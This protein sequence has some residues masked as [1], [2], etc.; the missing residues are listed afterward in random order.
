[1]DKNIAKGK[2]LEEMLQD[3]QELQT[4]L[5]CVPALI[6]YKDKGNRII[7]ANK[8][9]ATT[10]GKPIQDIINRS[11]SE[12]FPDDADRYLSDDQDVIKSGE[13]KY[14]IIEA[15][16]TPYGKKWLQTN[17]IP[18]RDS[19]GNI[20]GIIGF[21]VD[22]TDTILA[23]KSLRESEA[24][25][26]SLITNI[27]NVTWTTDSQG[28]TT[29]ISPNVENIYGYTP[30]E[31]CKKG[32]DLWF[33]RIHPADAGKVKNAFKEL[34]ENGTPL[35]VEYRIQRKDGQW[36]WLHDRSVTTYQK[37]GI[38]Y[39][40]GVL[41]DVTKRKQTQQALKDSEEKLRTI[42]EHGM[43]GILL[44]DTETKKFS[45][46]NR[47]VCQMLGYTED[48]LKNLG[49]EDIHPEQDLPYTIGQFEKLHRKESTIAKD[50]PVKRKDGTIFYV[51]IS[52]AP[53]Q[54]GGKTYVVGIF[55]NITHRKNTEEDLKKHRDRLEQLVNERTAELTE[56]NKQLEL[57]I[58]HHRQADKELIATKE[59]LQHLLTC[60]PV[61]IYACEPHANYAATYITENVL[62]Q[63]GYTQDEFIS[64]PDFWVSHIHPEDKER[65]IAGLSDI[66]QKDSYKYEYRFQYKDGSYHW[67]FDE[68]KVIH[69]A[70]GNATEI[71]GS[72]LD[73]TELKKAEEVMESLN[74]ELGVMVQ[75][76]NQSNYE[77]QDFIHIVAHDL[78]SPL[79]AI[80]ILTTL[81]STDYN[82]RFDEKGHEK[83]KLLLGRTER[84]N[85]LIEGILQYAG[86]KRHIQ[87]DEKVD[88]N[89]LTIEVITK[90]QPP[91]NIKITFENKLP[92]LICE[93]SH[94]TQVFQNLIDNAV[95]YMDKP[96][97]QIKIGCVEQDSLWRF[98][99]AD[100]GPGI[101]EKHCEKIFKPLQTLSA[102]DEYESTGIGLTV[103]KKIVELYN[104]KIW[105]ESK[106]G[107]GSTFFFTL[108]KQE[109]E[110]VSTSK[111][112]RNQQGN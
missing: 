42:F 54:L 76:L 3:N 87:K 97:G 53:V 108:P 91:E 112:A 69:D 72:V 79:R 90:I 111:N 29:F 21:S 15:M 107:K 25:Y 66:L 16:N 98:S 40:D 57:E 73:I 83:I 86:L 32:H 9:L 62:E 96:K 24:K 51:D 10:L 59:S 50:I 8:A 75:K 52:G 27:P 58:S 56:V 109:V 63:F 6:F 47:S 11:C 93:K 94:M 95:K 26:R 4:V 103:T 89:A 70:N 14:N 7:R 60:S 30:E 110:S 102:R 35:D 39:A 49:I 82:D 78:K 31:I 43:D 28:N 12:L 71:V 2:Q 44:A 101:E 37:Y 48:E 13:P 45:M 5:D 18:Y 33:G 77:L 81:L 41:S 61:V 68:L 67:V 105:I 17:K 106:P 38:Q 74:K 19:A 65:V 84:M 46:A 100:N 22:I 1:M 55:R 80:G 34:F 36:I 104:G 23:E 85:N 99:I 88:L 92:T 64:T 20:I